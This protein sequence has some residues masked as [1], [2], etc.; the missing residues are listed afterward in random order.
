MTD[1]DSTKDQESTHHNG[2]CS[3]AAIDQ[4]AEI[5]EAD[6][7]KSDD[8]FIVVFACFLFFSFVCHIAG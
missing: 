6:V 3:L 5:S 2:K 4:P 7:K 8:H 1:D